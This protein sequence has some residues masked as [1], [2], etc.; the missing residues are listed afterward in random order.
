MKTVYSTR[1][2]RRSFVLEPNEKFYS[3]SLESECETETETETETLNLPDLSLYDNLVYETQKSVK[4]ASMVLSRLV[5]RYD[6][7]T[8]LYELT[9]CGHTRNHPLDWRRVRFTALKKDLIQLFTVLDHQ[10][11]P[12]SLGHVGLEVTRDDNQK[13]P[14]VVFSTI[15]SIKKYLDNLVEM[16]NKKMH[17]C[18][19]SQMQV[20]TRYKMMASG[21]GSA[22]SAKSPFTPLMYFSSTRMRTE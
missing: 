14:V 10:V 20:D 2:Q 18:K 6:L 21:V 16:R 7:E 5:Y 11:I 3:I 17:T 9:R 4:H 19:S 8:R 12:L 1:N 13:E 15:S 22:T